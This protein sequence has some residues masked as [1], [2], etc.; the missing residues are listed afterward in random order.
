MS[1]EYHVEPRTG[2]AFRVSKGDIVRVVD[3]EGKQVADL[4]CFGTFPFPILSNV[5]K[6]SSGRTMEYNETIYPSEGD[7]LYSSKSN[8]M[9]KIIEDKGGRHDLLFSPCNQDTYRIVY[10]INEEHPNCLGNLAKNLREFGIEE[11]WI[12]DTFNL[13]M[14]VEIGENGRIDVKSPLTEAGDYIEFEAQMDLIIGVAACSA[15]KCNNY[16]CKPI[17]VIVYERSEIVPLYDSYD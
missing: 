6:F 9:L 17:E 4:T 15:Y 12:Q 7:Y 3:I 8:K 14:N 1:K 16:K 10:S 5:E 13:F 2:V 11:S